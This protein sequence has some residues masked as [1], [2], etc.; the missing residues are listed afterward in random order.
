MELRTP[1]EE[2]LAKVET[3]L[4]NLKAYLM[5]DT[6]ADIE[7]LER[8]LENM[9]KQIRSQFRWLIGIYLTTFMAIILL[10]VGLN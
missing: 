9:E 2:R 7:K 3:E 5:N 6:N 8:R 4:K 10:I 1:V